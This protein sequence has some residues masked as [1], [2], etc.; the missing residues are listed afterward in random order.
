MTPLRIGLIG[1]EQANALDI[2]GPAEAWDL[3]RC[4]SDETRER[5]RREW[6]RERGMRV[7][8]WR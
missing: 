1:Y 5:W 2:A 8:R 7:R 6:Q 4:D 3:Y